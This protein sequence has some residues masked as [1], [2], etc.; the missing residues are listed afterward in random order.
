M[1]RIMLTRI[2]LLLG[3]FTAVLLTLL[4]F[5]F[6]IASPLV[7]GGSCNPT[8]GVASIQGAIDNG[9]CSVINVGA[10]T[11]NEN[12]AIDRNVTIRGQ[13]SSTI[14]NGGGAG[15]VLTIDG[16]HT[17][18]LE[19]MRFTN[20]NATSDSTSPRNGGGI[21]AI[22]GA[23]LH[24][25]NIYVDNNVASTSTSTGFGGGIAVEINSSAYITNASISYNTANLQNASLFGAGRGGGLYINNNVYLSVYN[26]HVYS[27]TA[28][29][30][31]NSGQSATGGGLFV[32][33]NTTVSLK[34]NWWQYNIA[35]GENSAS[36]PLSTCVGGNNTEGGGA[37]GSHVTTPGATAVLNIYGDSFS[38]NIANNV[39]AGGTDNSA[40]GG[41]IALNT[42]NTGAHITTTLTHVT[43][44][45]NIAARV[46]SVAPPR[47]ATPSGGSTED[48]RGGAIYARH[49]AINIDKSTLRNNEAALATSGSGQAYGGGIYMREPTTGDYIT[50]TNSVLAGNTASNL[51]TAGAQIH[52]DY[53]AGS[54]NEATILN[55]TLADDTKSQTVALFYNGT[56]AGDNL[57]LGNTIF[58]NHDNGFGAVFATGQA[59]PR[60]LLFYNVD[61]DKTVATGGFPGDDETTWITG[62]PLFADAAN[63]DYHITA[64]SAA[65]NTGTNEAG[66]YTD[67]DIDNQPRPL[68]TDYDIG[69]DEL[70]YP[71][72]LPMII[73]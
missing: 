27:N 65:Y 62:N 72:Y 68:F 54:S 15:R 71:V 22:N 61:N 13:G 46:A 49:T 35:R 16:S 24:A 18:Y 58:A 37:I 45:N 17:V 2:S 9:A 4:F 64:G 57:I 73:K 26:S 67:D 21:L 59:R 70:V 50:V 11:F 1:K 14:V 38:Y 8:E 53:V 10:G 43:M 3:L 19:N 63:G 28:A 39:D 44:D 47:P 60:Y 56:S 51:T 41:A 20:G 23:T 66:F 30:R 36:C 69:A 52:I 55:S 6:A 32:Q 31:A 34:N 42:S 48:G 29:S 33:E 25:T 7:A 12:L 40:R 5:L